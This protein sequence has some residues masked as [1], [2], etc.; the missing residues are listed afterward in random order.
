MERQ[1]AIFLPLHFFDLRRGDDADAL[2]EHLLHQGLAEHGIELPQKMLFAQKHRYIRT[3]RIEHTGDLH[4][5][6]SAADNRNT[7]RS[8]SQI[9]KSIGGYPQLRPFYRWNNGIGTGCDDDMIRTVV[10]SAHFERMGIDETG[11]ALN[12]IDIGICKIGVIP[13]VN[14]SDVLI[15]L[16]L[17]F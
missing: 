16:L 6:V 4:G 12:L 7:F 17:Q 9:K 11:I 8:F 3:Q 10:A 2:I 15:P 1:G 13:A 14:V 5:N